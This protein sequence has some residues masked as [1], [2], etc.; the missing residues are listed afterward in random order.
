MTTMTVVVISLMVLVMADV[1]ADNK[2]IFESKTPGGH[3][4]GGGDG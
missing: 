2:E 4:G 1:P 3:S